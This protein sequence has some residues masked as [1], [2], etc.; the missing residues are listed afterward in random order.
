M[1]FELVY[2]NLEEKD[3]NDILYEIASIYKYFYSLPPRY[4][5]INF[6]KILNE[7]KEDYEE[8]IFILIRNNEKR[9]IGYIL[10]ID[11]KN[12]ID[13]DKLSFDTDAIYIKD[14]VVLPEYRGIKLMKELYTEFLNNCENL[15]FKKI[16]TRTRKDVN[17]EIVLLLNNEFKIYYKYFATTNSVTTERFVYEKS[18]N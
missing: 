4:E 7:F 9:I 14:Y 15:G 6:D 13:F 12:F 8:G 1:T 5:I 2:N 18:F 11:I 3:R 10:G 17:D 16:Y